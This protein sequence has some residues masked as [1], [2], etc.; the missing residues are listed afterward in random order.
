MKDLNWALKNNVLY[1]TAQ[2]IVEKGNREI[3]TIQTTL[4]FIKQH[5]YDYRIIKTY[6]G[7]NI[8]F[9]N[10]VDVLLYT[11]SVFDQEHLKENP[12]IH[13]HGKVSWCNS[14]FMDK[15]FIW[16]NPRIVK[17]CNENIVV[18]NWEADL[19]IH[20]AHMNYETGQMTYNERRYLNEVFS[21]VR[22]GACT[23]QAQKY[24]WVETY[25]NT[26]DLL[27][28]TI[29]H[30][31]FPV[32]FSRGHLL[33]AVMEK[34]VYGYVFKKLRKSLRILLTGNTERYLQP[35]ERKLL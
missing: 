25:L 27:C 9:G 22:L 32:R 13:L 19:L 10:D 28:E 4:Q 15:E 31:E 14:Q 12:R 17:Y 6:R 18:P 34:K 8:R 33:K 11:E 35:P 20:L 21:N 16:D 26:L 7:S 3:E 24:H 29:P 1:E 30:Y 2:L 23:R 5:Y